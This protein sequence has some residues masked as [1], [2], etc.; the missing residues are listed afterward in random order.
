[1]KATVGMS[2]SGGAGWTASPHRPPSGR[3]R[4]VLGLLGDFQLMCGEVS[5]DASPSARRLLALLALSGRPVTRDYAAG[6]LWPD[7]GAT[8]ASGSLRSTLW[9]LPRPGGQTLVDATTTHVTITPSVRVDVHQAERDAHR[10][11]TTHGPEACTADVTAFTAD[12][13]VD[14]WQEW[15]VVAREHYRQLR[16]HALEALSRRHAD[17]GRFAEA[18]SVAMLAVASEPLRDSAQR[19][20]I[21]VHLAEG[22]PTEALRHYDLYRERLRRETGL[23]PSS[24]LRGLVQTLRPQRTSA[25]PTR[26]GP[27]IPAAAAS[28]RFR[29]HA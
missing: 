3:P 13:L 21:E 23:S 20:V 4:P 12:V 18:L 5:V 25:P 24:A 14:W 10:I 1:V 15:V 26:V 8:R 2:P 17:A 27:G 9:R 29:A 6:Q 22:N 19:L 16:L 7:V 28:R 11:L